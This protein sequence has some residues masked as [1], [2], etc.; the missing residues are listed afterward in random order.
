MN[1]IRRIARK[2]RSITSLIIISMKTQLGLH[3]VLNTAMRYVVGQHAGHVDC[4]D[5]PF[6]HLV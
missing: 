2:H 6:G 5:K 1:K 4:P 3:K